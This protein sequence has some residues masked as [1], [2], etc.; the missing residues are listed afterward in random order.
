[1]ADSPIDPAERERR[2]DEALGA[3][4][5]AVAAAQNPD[6]QALIARHPELAGELAAF[7]ADYDRLHRLA[8]PL[9]PVAQAARAAD[10]PTEPATDSTAADAPAA[11]PAVA[12]PAATLTAD[13]PGADRTADLVPYAAPVDGE[14]VELVKG[15]TL[16]YFGDYE[17][18][19]ILGRGGMGVV[20]QAKQLSLNRPV[21]LKMIRAGTWAS[22]DEVR[23]FRNEAEAVA[24]L[25]HPRI[26]TIHEVG[27]YDGR[28]YFS[29]RL[30][31]GP[32]L[33][34][35]LDQYA[36]DP[37]RAAHL[38][39][40]V[41]R[42]VHHAHQRGI[43]HRDLKPSNILLDGEGHPHVTDFGLAK[44]L[45]GN[46]SLSVSGSI[47]GTPRYMSPEQAAGSK[48]A[49][50]T[51]TD[52]YGLG[53]LLYAALTAQPPFQS[54][55]VVETLRQV[56][57][58]PVAAPS[59]VNP[60]VDRDLETICLKCLEK[61]PR[62]RYGSADALAEELERYLRG[63][64]I[65]ARRTGIPERVV[66]WARRR[67]AIAA[68][69]ALVHI[70]G[71][72]G[73]AGIV[74]QWRQTVRA[75]SALDRANQDLGR[76]NSTLDQTNRTLRTNLYYNTIGLA[77]SELQ[78]K[79]PGRAAEHLESCFEPL[80]GWEWRYLRGRRF[81]EPLE[82]RG[83]QGPVT[84]VSFSPDGR[85]I[86]SAG[87]LDSTA[88]IWDAITGE[89]LLV[90]RGHQSS[91]PSVAFHPDGRRLVTASED[92]TVKLWDTTTGQELRTIRR[93]RG[94]M[95]CARFSPDGR[96]IISAAW[97]ATIRVWETD[98]GRLLRTF[99][100]ESQGMA[101]PTREG[102]GGAL[103]LAIHP[104]GR[105]IACS[106]FPT[107]MV[108]IWD[109]ETGEVLRTF[110]GLGLY[111]AISYSPDGRLLAVLRF[112]TVFRTQ[113]GVIPSVVILDATS[114]RIM[115]SMIGKSPTF[116]EAGRR[117]ATFDGREVKVWN[118][119]D[120][121]LQ[122]SLDV[123]TGPLGYLGTSPDGRRLAATT[124]EGE[125]RIW[126]APPDGEATDGEIRLLGEAPESLGVVAFRPGG[127]QLVAASSDGTAQI[128][129]V[130]SGR[131][132]AVLRGHDGPV[133]D[134]TYSLDGR[135]LATAGLDMTVRLWDADTGGL[136]RTLPKLKDLVRQVLF[137]PDGA[138]VF[139]KLAHSIHTWD[140]TTERWVSEI[141]TSA[142]YGVTQDPGGRYLVVSLTS[143]M[144][145]YDARTSRMIREV[146]ATMPLR[147]E[148]APDGQ[149]LASIGSD[150]RI[151]IWETSDWTRLLTLPGHDRETNRVAFHPDGRWLASGGE[152]GTLIL[153]DPGTG[154]IVRTLRGNIGGVNGLAFSPDGRWLAASSGIQGRGE[155]L[156]WDLARLDVTREA[157]EQAARDHAEG[158]RL[159][160][161]KRWDEAR[162]A[163][164][165]T[166]ETRQ[167]LVRSHPDD[168]R[169]V[170]DLAESYRELGLALLDSGQPHAALEPLQQTLLVRDRLAGRRPV[171]LDA[172]AALAAAY[173]DLYRVMVALRRWDDAAPLLRRAIEAQ[174]AH[175][176]RRP[177]D[178]YLRREL[179]RNAWLLA[180]HEQDA[181]HPEAAVR[182]WERCIG[183]GAT[184]FRDDPENLD[185]QYEAR[186]PNFFLADLLSGLG[187]H[188]EALG[189]IRGGLDVGD[190]TDLDRRLRDGSIQPDW[191]IVENTRK[192]LSWA[193]CLAAASQ[194]ALGRRTEAERSLQEGMTLLGRIRRTDDRYFN[195]H[196]F[197]F[198]LSRA[199]SLAG[200]IG[201]DSAPRGSEERRALEDRAIAALQRSL[202]HY[203]KGEIDWRFLATYRAMLRTSPSLD[204][205]RHRA[206]FQALVQDL[207]FPSWPFTGDPS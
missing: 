132:L 3:H 106:Y 18:R 206:D 162:A 21:A 200:A 110:P 196:D 96:R 17:L 141:N 168:P 146:P 45:E 75:N 90:L 85:R 118:T 180:G 56:Q 105:Q 95:T 153:W 112:G 157:R 92:G 30:V 70:T 115:M 42:A 48:R 101:H 73:L 87:L 89:E 158:R 178:R 24:N 22:D 40:A 149:R 135:L 188:E 104:D 120:G 55:S 69:I 44:R 25:D 134:V 179:C 29:M 68:L 197:A 184:L 156:L 64:P 15:T 97:D 80:R 26:V 151:T 35:V 98:T 183:Q 19:R 54:D 117:I 84:D 79:S 46:G 163:L 170:R 59:R 23:R 60:Q 123:P 126:D 99:G 57:E 36:A 182:W 144:A 205:L 13:Q 185:Y 165:R 12:P 122:I 109:L 148:F 8:Q 159:A 127:R 1:M 38:V 100:E 160:A 207:D 175:L 16:R 72:A 67:P 119:S 167:E 193:R 9:L 130:A 11:S 2:L 145:I 82:L 39:A 78:G 161:A 174:E 14:E 202:E 125:I 103:W 51:A 62:R 71:L 58:Q 173:Q 93:H 172:G 187:R 31:E 129:E 136:R 88:R 195:Q 94:A 181:G 204:P 137:S 34:K 143:A 33:E 171:D 37:R 81:H 199:S 61:D 191:L 47:V 74:W 131:E 32:S 4:L 152:D 86:A 113:M 155:V 107:H 124:V 66:K 150:R 169:L 140:L 41:A 192:L 52:V 83:H 186:W 10:P 77:A 176:S 177:G 164:R 114:G 43:L 76:T 201:P 138:H 189:F 147:T 203:T 53:A 198:L 128:W 121:R 108:K 27:Q 7:F 116:L 28:H 194:A 190:E 49:I 154:R 5:E 166:L 111:G 91:V 142:A 133:T 50:T 65:L 63:E 6:R 20:Y 102:I 139:A